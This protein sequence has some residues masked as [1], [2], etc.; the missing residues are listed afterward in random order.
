MVEYGVDEW[1]KHLRFRDYLRSHTTVAALYAD[2]K[3][4]FATLYGENREAYT[5][6]KSAFILGVLRKAG[7]PETAESR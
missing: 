3:K 1:W 6:S 2:L 5:E 4:G 7:Y